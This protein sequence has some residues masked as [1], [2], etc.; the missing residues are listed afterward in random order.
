[1]AANDS[2][3]STPTEPTTVQRPGLMRPCAKVFG[4]VFVAL[5]LYLL[6]IGPAGFLVQKRVLTHKQ[7]YKIYAPIHTLCRKYECVAELQ[8]RYVGFWLRL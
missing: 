8:E 2:D 5:I 4:T 3:N 7:F 1:M 6:G